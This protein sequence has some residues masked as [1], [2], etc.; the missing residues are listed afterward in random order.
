VNHQKC[1]VAER[2]REARTATENRKW[3][4]GGKKKKYKRKTMK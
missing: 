4:I 2:E 1:I 3:R